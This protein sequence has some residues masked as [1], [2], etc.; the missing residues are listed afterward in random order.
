MLTLSLQ[1]VMVTASIVRARPSTSTSTTGIRCSPRI[2]ATRS[3]SPFLPS[4][5]TAGIP[6][7][8][9]PSTLALIAST[10]V[11]VTV[12]LSPA[13]RCGARWASMN[14]ISLPS[15]SVRSS[16]THSLRAVSTAIASTAAT[17]PT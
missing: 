3:A 9:S 14:A 15:T 10:T 4:T 13:M 12:L 5:T 17:L 16:R 6:T 2:V 8:P 1:T 7:D 11:S